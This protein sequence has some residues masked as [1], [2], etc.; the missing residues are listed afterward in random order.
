M[1]KV[2]QKHVEF[3]R[4]SPASVPAALGWPAACG[5]YRRAHS[6]TGGCPLH[7]HVEIQA[8]AAGITLVGGCQLCHLCPLVLP[9]AHR[10]LH[11]C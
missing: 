1:E 5:K 9:T 10:L 2:K 7:Q 3:G 8:P 11:A 4:P 6:S